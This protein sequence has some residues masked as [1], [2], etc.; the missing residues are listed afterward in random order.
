MSIMG[1]CNKPHVGFLSS[2]LSLWIHFSCKT[3]Y[4]TLLFMLFLA[5]KKSVVHNACSFELSLILKVL[6]DLAAV[7]LKYSMIMQLSVIKNHP[8]RETTYSFVSV[9]CSLCL[10]DFA[11]SLIHKCPNGVYMPQINQ[12][13]CNLLLASSSDSLLNPIKKKYFSSTFMNVS[14]P[15]ILIIVVRLLFIYLSYPLP[16]PTLPSMIASWKHHLNLFWDQHNRCS[17]K[18]YLVVSKCHFLFLCFPQNRR[19]TTFH[20]KSRKYKTLS[21]DYNKEWKYFQF[22]VCLF[23]GQEVLWNNLN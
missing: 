5:Q 3:H 16:T 4:S 6:H 19:T 21:G 14:M 15:K 8:A 13:K 12:F 23:I 1:N 17:V 20:L 10:E 2:G 7:H 22:L 11:C 18:H 9:S